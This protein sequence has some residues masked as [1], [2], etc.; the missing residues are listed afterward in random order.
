MRP[1][2]KIIDLGALRHNW[3]V[4]SKQ[5]GGETIAVVKANAYGHDIVAVANTLKDLAKIFA[6]ASI[7]EALTLRANGIT[8]PIMLLEGVFSA[9]EL[10]ICADLGLQ[11]V[12]HDERQIYWLKQ[13]PVQITAWLKIDSGMHRLGFGV[14]Q[15]KAAIELAKSCNNVKWVGVVSHFACA[16]EGNLNHARKQIQALRTLPLPEG[17]ARCYANSAAIFRLPEC[18]YEYTRPGIMLYGISPFDY[19]TG[20][21]FDLRPVMSLQTEVIAIRDLNRGEAAGYG[22]AFIAPQQ[23]CIAIIALGYGDGYPRE[24]DTGRVPVW[25]NGK[26]YPVVGRVAM[27]TMMVWLGYKKCTVGTPVEIFGRNLPIEEVARRAGTIPYTL[28]TMLTQRVR[29]ITQDPQKS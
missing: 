2:Q 12:I 1:L 17:W 25:I 11:P 8:Q 24:I 19:G 22:R 27:D 6:V 16:D 7:E 14:N 20:M 29:T 5:S 9:D 15:G 18:R 3:K 21:D 10:V 26:F 13:S 28:T 23:G 4:I